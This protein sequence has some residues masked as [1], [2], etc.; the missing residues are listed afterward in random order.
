MLNTH[1]FAV[2]DRVGVKIYDRCSDK[3]ELG[4]EVLK[5]SQLFVLLNQ[6]F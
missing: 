5:I 4:D 2:A 6:Q 3:Y 1:L